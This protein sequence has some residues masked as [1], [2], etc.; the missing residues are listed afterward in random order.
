MHEWKKFTSYSKK[1]VQ[2]QGKGSNIFTQN[3]FCPKKIGGWLAYVNNLTYL[4]R[5]LFFNETPENMGMSRKEAKRLVGKMGTWNFRRQ[6]G[7]A[8]DTR[9]DDLKIL[10]KVKG[11]HFAYGRYMLTVNIVGGEG[12]TV[13]EDKKV[14]IHEEEEW[15]HVCCGRDRKVLFLQ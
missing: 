11:A 8:K 10:V 14:E 7:R 13:V 2:V 3:N 6:R 12:E 4:C 1:W 9:Y 5:L 15:N